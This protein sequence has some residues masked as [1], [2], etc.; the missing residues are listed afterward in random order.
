MKAKHSK[1]TLALATLVLAAGAQAQDK[2]DGQWRGNAGA[3]AAVTSGNTSSETLAF[4]G[5]LVRATAGDKIT[6]LGNVNY[7]R[8]KVDGVKKTN[9]DKWAGSGQY[10]LNFTPSL[11]GFGKLGLESDRIAKLSLRTTLAGGVGYKLID[12]PTMA[13]SVFGGAG[14]STDKY[15]ETQ[16]IGDKTDT[17]FSRFSL[18]VG[19]E[20]SQQLATNTTFKQ[21]LEVY[22]GIS[23]DKAVLAK[24]N[25]GL[26]VAM[27]SAMSLNVGLTDSYNSKPPLGQKKNDLGV[28]TGINVKIGA[29]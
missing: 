28:F 23:G 17:R 25:A 5:D 14:W 12:T 22:P 13:F 29:N 2:P 21:R 11:Y 9:T 3:A 27:T 15:S 7:G 10:D 16:T 1:I 26:A 4:T 24:F 6:L 19:E 20:Y 18:L 8:A